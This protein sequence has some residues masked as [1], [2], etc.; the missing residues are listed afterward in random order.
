MYTLARGSL[1]FVHENCNTTVKLG[2]GLAL[3]LQYN[4]IVFVNLTLGCFLTYR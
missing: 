1:S 3:S 4:L 2:M